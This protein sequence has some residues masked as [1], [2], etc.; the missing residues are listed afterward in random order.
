MADR[1]AALSSHKA[2]ANQRA[3]YQQLEHIAPGLRNY[4]RQRL[5]SAERRRLI[6]PGLYAP[7]D[8]LDD[9]L[10][11]VYEHFDEMPTDEEALRIKLF[12]LANERLDELLQ[13]EAW[14]RN[15]VSLEE[16]LSDELKLMDEIP[17][18]TVDAD[19]DILLVE[20]LDDAELAPQEPKLVLLEDS[21]EEELMA[22][23]GLDRRLVKADKGQRAILAHLYDRLPEQSRILLDLWTR[24]KLTVEEIAKVRAL[25][26]EQ[27]Q[28]ILQRIRTE[29]QQ[30]LQ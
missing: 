26:V 16:L 6:P 11:H 27:V 28:T 10:L 17:L 29:F 12:Q 19:G 8:V 20:E 5:L 18:I 3:F 30:R 25:S 13:D 22:T 15:A 2:Q 9:V 7:E 23:L 4:I 24:G 21:F 1:T 14:H